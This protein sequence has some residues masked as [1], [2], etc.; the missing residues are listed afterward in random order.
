VRI[1]VVSNFYPPRHVGG[2]EICCKQAVDALRARGHDVAVLTSTHGATPPVVEDGVHRLLSYRPLDWHRRPRLRRA[3][4]IPLIELRNRALFRRAAR[5]LQPDVVQFWNMSQI[6]LSAIDQARRMGFPVSFYIHDSWLARMPILDPWHRLALRF[7][8][9]EPSLPNVQFLSGYLMQR[10]LAAGRDFPEAEVVHWG[11][12]MDVFS[13]RRDAR[14]P[15]RFLYAGQL[16]EHKGVHVALEAFAMVK[17]Q[18]GESVDLT[19]TVAGPCIDDRYLCKLRRLVDERSLN[20]AVAFLGALPHEALPGLYAAHD[21]LVFPS[22]SENEG[23]P[24]TLLEAMASGTVVCS[25]TAS[26]ARELV[27]DGRNAVAFPIGDVG[28]CAAAL[29]RLVNDQRLFERLRTEARRMV[30]TRFDINSA[31]VAIERGLEKASQ[32]K[33][34]S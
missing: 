1:L 17:H 27:E 30:E 19:L 8:G 13:F 31:V 28:A 5:A 25:T 23:L 10:A 2:Y 6:S 12:D 20:G 33:G 26:G 14:P 9:R 34:S 15:R 16:V 29:V 7:G 4:R 18:V 21:V 22:C 3:S 24:L 11:V 32:A